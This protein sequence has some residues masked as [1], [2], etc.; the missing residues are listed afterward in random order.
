MLSVIPPLHQD[1]RARHTFISSGDGWRTFVPPPFPTVQPAFHFLSSLLEQPAHVATTPL[2]K[3]RPPLNPSLYGSLERLKSLPIEVLDLI[4]SLV[5]DLET[6]P[7]IALSCR[8]FNRLATRHLYKTVELA[9]HNS[10]SLLS[11]SLEM[12]PILGEHI[13]QLFL[14]CHRP[15]WDQMHKLV[16]ALGRNARTISALR[17]RFQSSD[18]YTAMPFFAYF[19]PESFEWVTSPCWMMRPAN[20]FSEFLSEWTRLRYLTFGNF[21]FDYAIVESVVKLS[22]MRILTLRGGGCGHLDTETLSSL[23]QL[24]GKSLGQHPELAEE[25]RS[26]KLHIKDC[27]L[28]DRFL[29]QNELLASL[30]EDDQALLS[31]LTW[32]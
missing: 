4:V 25:K 2:V 12:R 27:P 11:R 28:P 6:G 16:K 23:L 24:N 17:V 19:S 7:S 14:L 29:L 10:V 5:V 9:T 31:R 20:L 30:A 15:Q 26:Y 8:Q 22:S 21:R 18:L 32:L 13:Q 3:V 1:F